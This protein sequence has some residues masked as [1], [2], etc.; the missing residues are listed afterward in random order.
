[1]S[2]RFLA[3]EDFNRAIVNGLLRLAPETDIVRVQDVGLRTLD[4][5]TILAWAAREGA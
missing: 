2:V 1:M 4:D 3:D 5:P